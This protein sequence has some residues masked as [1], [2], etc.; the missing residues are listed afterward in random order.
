M[1]SRDCQTMPLVQNAILIR[2]ALMAVCQCW[3]E[4]L[5]TASAGKEE[6]EENRRD[7]IN[8]VPA[9]SVSFRVSSALSN[10]PRI[11]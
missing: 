5:M 4:F 1:V 6:Q 11:R 2:L 8:S 10:Q 9:V 3:V 7:M